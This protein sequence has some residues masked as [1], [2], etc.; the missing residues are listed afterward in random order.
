MKFSTADL[1]FFFKISL[2]TSKF[3]FAGVANI[4]VR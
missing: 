4:A 2:P 1:I 3:R